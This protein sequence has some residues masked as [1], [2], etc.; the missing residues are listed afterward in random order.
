MKTNFEL[1]PARRVNKGLSFPFT[2]TLIYKINGGSIT[3]LYIECEHMQ[4]KCKVSYR[5]VIDI[6]YI[7]FVNTC[8]LDVE[9]L[10]EGVVHILYIDSVNTSSL[11]VKCLT[12]GVVHILYIDIVNIHSLN[13]MFLTEGV[14]HN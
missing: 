13:A 1:N 9:F 10:T 7:D 6:L 12:E 2:I 5:G 4:F 14:V 3:H 11:N 8:S